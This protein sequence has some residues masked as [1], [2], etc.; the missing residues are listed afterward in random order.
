ML[1]V[2][3]N[4]QPNFGLP[5][6]L[7]TTS[8]SFLRICS[9]KVNRRWVNSASSCALDLAEIKIAANC[10]AWNLSKYCVSCMVTSFHCTFSRLHIR[11]RQP[12]NGKHVFRLPYPYSGLLPPPRRRSTAGV[13]KSSITDWLAKSAATKFAL[14]TSRAE[15]KMLFILWL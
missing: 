7:R 2:A 11:K 9:A 12:E 14:C 6:K 1:R 15:R 3:V 8:W 10:M 13:S 4:Q 5:I